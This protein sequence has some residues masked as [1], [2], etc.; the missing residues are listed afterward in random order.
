MMSDLDV[1]LSPSLDRRRQADQFR[2]R[3]A[4]TPLDAV[5]V[6]YQGRNYVN[7]ASNNY[8][9]LTHH[10]RV[11]DAV[12]DAARRHGAGAGAAS[13]VSGYT[14][15]H[16]RAEAAVASWKGTESA[17]LFPSGYQAN[18]AA[19][20][21]LAQLPGRP[22][23]LLDKLAH[24]SLVEAVRS[25]GEAFRVFPHNHLAKLRRL[26]EEADAGQP[27]VVVTDSIFSMDGDAADL[28][29]L[30]QLKHD[31]PFI[32]L[33]DEAH[34]SGVYGQDG[35]G[36]AAEMGLAEIADLGILTFSK[37][38]G[39]MGGAVCGSAILRDALLNGAPAAIYSTNLP[40]M[41]AGGIEAA[42]TLLREE[43]WRRTRVRELAMRVRRALGEGGLTV[44]AGDSPIIPVILGSESAALQAAERLRE[45][46]LWVVAI[47]PP[48]VAPS[49][50]RLRITVSCEHSEEEIERLIHA[51]REI[52][53]AINS[54]IRRVSSP[55][56]AV[57]AAGSG[58]R[59]NK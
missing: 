27:Q 3:R 21:L 7:F 5:H 33:L 9:G 53:A 41:L 44:P 6:Q 36:Y 13:L 2:V 43:P 26:I 57:R 16:E 50:S 42:I 47:R 31:H 40:P 32:L 59:T 28:A 12:A 45:Q 17:V 30:A 38:L 20:Q 56:A 10:P 58:A 37:G 19:V 49:S 55:Q 22:R 54:P 24:A 51:A 48:T 46:G 25:S 29:G 11:L 4:L 1:L 18:Q 8:L 39:L 52:Y 34:A 23:F 14:C 35:S 15:V